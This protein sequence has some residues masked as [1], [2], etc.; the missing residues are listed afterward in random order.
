MK[1]LNILLLSALAAVSGSALAM[2]GTVEQGKNFTNLNLEMGKSSSG[3]YVESNWLKNT[4][5]GTQ[6]GG[7]N[8][9]LTDSIHLYGEGYAAPEGLNNSVKNYVEANGGVSWTPITPVTLKVGYRHVSVDGKDGRPG[10][11]LIDGAYVGG[12]VTF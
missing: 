4:D 3:L 8:V 9:A 10:H 1:K 7:V 12:G 6:T 11:T 2:G 5:D